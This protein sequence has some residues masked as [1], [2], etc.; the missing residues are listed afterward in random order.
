MKKHL[1]TSLLLSSLALV[2]CSS[3]ETP[4]LDQFTHF[5]G[6]KIM[7]DATSLYWMT[8]RLTRVS[9]AADY[10]TLVR[11]VI[12]HCDIVCCRTYACKTLCHP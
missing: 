6:G 3:V 8:E 9:T 11:A 7:G 5:S 4:N 12:S 10:I 1:L 2:G